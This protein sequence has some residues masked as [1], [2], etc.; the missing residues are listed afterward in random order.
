MYNLTK[1]NL[2]FIEKGGERY[3]TYQETVSKTNAG[4]LYQKKLKPK[5]VEVREVQHDRCVVK[6]AS[7]YL[8][9]CDCD[10]MYIF[11]QPI[12]NPNGYRWFS[13]MRLGLHSCQK[14]LKTMAQESGLS[15]RI[16]NHTLRKTTVTRLFS[17]NV[18]DKVIRSITGHRSRDGLDAYKTIDSTV[19]NNAFHCIRGSAESD[20]VTPEERKEPSCFNLTNC[21]VTI[22]Y[23]QK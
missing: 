15:G 18:D 17:E 12:R 9:R 5:H 1:S 7:A 11:C 22:N 20:N 6:I 8:Q 23:N 2:Y 10:S 14:M 16:T 21:S 19:M 3:L 4:G 13:K